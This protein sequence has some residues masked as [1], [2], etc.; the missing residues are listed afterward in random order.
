MKEN[1]DH[2]SH[3]EERLLDE[4]KTVVTQRATEAELS[5]GMGS[6]SPGRRRGPRLAFGAAAVCAAAAAMLVVNSG[7][8]DTP[9]AFA[10]EQLANRA[11]RR[12]CRPG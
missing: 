4:L 8:G 6:N 2:G 7:G 5:T 11:C 12:P 1:R 10:V 3:F 9:Q